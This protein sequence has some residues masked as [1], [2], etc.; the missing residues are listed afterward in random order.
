MVLLQDVREGEAHKSKITKV[1]W[2]GQAP[3]RNARG[4]DFQR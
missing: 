2:A 1:L 3:G 4:L